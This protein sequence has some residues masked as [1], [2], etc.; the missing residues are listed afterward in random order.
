MMRYKEIECIYDN[1][2]KE[3]IPIVSPRKLLRCM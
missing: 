3:L 1:S 2:P